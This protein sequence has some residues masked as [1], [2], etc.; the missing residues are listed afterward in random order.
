[1]WTLEHY[2]ILCT[3]LVSIIYLVYGVC[4]GKVWLR[5]LSQ[6]GCIPVKILQFASATT[7]V[8]LSLAQQEICQEMTDH[9]PAHSSSYSQQMANPVQGLEELSDAVLGSGCIAQVHAGTFE[10]EACITKV[11]HPLVRAELWILWWSAPVVFAYM[12]WFLGMYGQ[13]ES[14]CRTI[15]EQADF[16]IEADSTTQFHIIAAATK[17]RITVPQI[18]FVNSD[19]LIMSR[20]DGQH[21]TIQTVGIARM[22]HILLRVGGF[23][24]YTGVCFGFC[25]GDMH[26]GNILYCATTDQVGLIDFGICLRVGSF[27]QNP[28]V[29]LFRF[30]FTPWD[31]LLSRHVFF[32]L[33]V[34][35]IY[36]SDVMERVRALFLAH[37]HTI[38]PC[39]ELV[40]EIRFLA[41]EYDISLQL[42]SFFYIL[43]MDCISTQLLVCYPDCTLN[44][45]MIMVQ[46][47]LEYARQAEEPS[48][49]AF[50]SGISDRFSQCYGQYLDAM[51]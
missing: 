30:A 19:M 15:H 4:T 7:L 2:Q 41:K 13:Q 36:R 26:S 32:T 33:F 45:L 14:L 23:F 38:P 11:R 31:P 42:Q 28:L 18:L 9:A 20:V 48:H 10:Q 37:S 50:L 39:S 34:G 16:C 25:H 24:L 35:R 29:V 51:L 44:P 21:P 22:R 8:E 27:D 3:R 6:L 5:H 47:A 49:V 43:Q 46:E 40:A 17:H 1:M 12:E